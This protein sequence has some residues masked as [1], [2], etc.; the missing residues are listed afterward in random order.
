MWSLG[1]V[2]KCSESAEG[3]A[4]QI[5][6]AWRRYLA[7]KRFFVLRHEH[8]QLRQQKFEWV[9]KQE[10]QEYLQLLEADDFVDSSEISDISCE[11]EAR[12]TGCLRL[13]MMD[14]DT[15][16]ATVV[17]CEGHYRSRLLR[18]MNSDLKWQGFCEAEP[19]FLTSKEKRRRM[20]QQEEESMRQQEEQSQLD[21][22]ILEE[23]KAALIHDEAKE[24]TTIEDVSFS[25]WQALRDEMRTTQP[26]LPSPGE[27]R[28]L[29]QRHRAATQL[30]CVWRGYTTRR[31]TGALADFYQEMR[32]IIREEQLMRSQ[33][34]RA[35]ASDWPSKDRLSVPPKTPAPAA[36]GPRTKGFKE[37]LQATVAT[38]PPGGDAAAAPT[39]PEANPP[40]PKV[41]A[42]RPAG[43]RRP[44]PSDPLKGSL[45]RDKAKPWKDPQVGTPTSCPPPPGPPATRLSSTTPKSR[46][47]RQGELVRRLVV[48][49]NQTPEMPAPMSP[50]GLYSPLAP[51][52]NPWSP[53]QGASSPFNKSLPRPPTTARQSDA[54]DGPSRLSSLANTPI[55]TPFCIVPPGSFA[56]E[57]A[58]A[59]GTIDTIPSPSTSA[60]RQRLA[61]LV[62]L[63]LDAASSPS[64]K[65]RKH[66]AL[67]EKQL[68]SAAPVF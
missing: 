45:V 38:A 20:Q 29:E 35:Q 46:S 43:P 57:A 16:R 50:S 53:W 64:S 8:E 3:S 18:L 36:P 23:D 10:E 15:E 1:R 56:A 65:P 30:Q 17:R 2:A 63:A 52:T 25:G 22:A 7:R 67:F 9:Q 13:L 28:S 48:P 54:S 60:C 39:A 49:K 14:E 12:S 58:F 33:I 55:S 26:G 21:V 27:R 34:Q 66:R 11:V 41:D 47:T 37:R 61:P 44:A 62:P 40:P 24:R 42:P 32:L 68:A 19:V 51:A 4:L 6:S 59:M 31:R 5:Q